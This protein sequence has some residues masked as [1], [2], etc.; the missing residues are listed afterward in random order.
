MLQSSVSSK[1]RYHPDP[2]DPS[3][4]VEF[5]RNVDGR[6]AAILRYCDVGGKTVIDLGCSNGFF[7]FQLASSA[8]R[9]VGVDRDHDIVTRNRA[10]AR[11]LGVTNVDFVEADLTPNL[12]GSDAL[13]NADVALFLSVMHHIVAYTRRSRPNG[14]DEAAIEVALN[15]L[16]AVRKKTQTLCFEMGEPGERYGWARNLPEKMRQDPQDWIRSRLLE[17]AGFEIIHSIVAPQWRGARR[18]VYKTIRALEVRGLRPPGFGRL[19]SYDV[20]DGRT[21]FIAK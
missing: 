14:G 10:V 9:V 3:R 21:L 16:R 19:L 18:A 7:C 4:E 2:A 5:L 12:V 20:R 11:Q 13:P 1:L 8:T 15:L 6:L 17:P